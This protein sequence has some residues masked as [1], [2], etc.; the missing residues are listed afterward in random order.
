[1]SELLSPIEDFFN[2]VKIICENFDLLENLNLL[3]IATYLNSQYSM[4]YDHLLPKLKSMLK[5]VGDKDKAII[6]YLNANEIIC[7]NKEWQ[8][9]KECV[10]YLKKSVELSNNFKFVNNRFYL[11]QCVKNSIAK[12]LAVESLNNVDCTHTFESLQKLSQDY[13]FSSQSFVDE[14]ILGISITDIVFKQKESSLIEKGL[15]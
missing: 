1:M 5:N 6:Y 11:A 2:A 4:G 9:N 3:Y 14:F 12:K 15:I 8:T 13:W 10:S 7:K